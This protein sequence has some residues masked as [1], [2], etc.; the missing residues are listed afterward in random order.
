[1]LTALLYFWCVPGSQVLY[2]SEFVPVSQ[3]FRPDHIENGC[4]QSIME[5]L[6]IIDANLKTKFT[7]TKKVCKRKTRTTL[8]WH[9]DATARP[10]STT[11]QQYEYRPMIYIVGYFQCG[12]SSFL[13]CWSGR[14]TYQ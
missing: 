9:S 2:P 14:G 13:E 6:T 4:R 12:V 3:H 1:M 5:E 10:E 8:S 7:N 11:S